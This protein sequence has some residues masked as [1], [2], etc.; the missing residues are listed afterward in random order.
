MPKYKSM[1]ATVKRLFSKHLDLNP[2]TWAQRLQYSIIEDDNEWRN[3]RCY[4][5]L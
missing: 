2:E 5:P 4:V 1:H 3:L